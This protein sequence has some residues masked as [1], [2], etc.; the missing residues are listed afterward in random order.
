LAGQGTGR[1]DL[2]VSDL[3]ATQLKNIVEPIRVY[4][5]EVGVSADAA[6]ATAVKRPV[7]LL[8]IGVGLAALLFLVAASAAIWRLASGSRFAAPVAE[9]AATVQ[10]AKSVPDLS[11]VVL[12][13]ANLSNDP[14]QDYFA[15][16]ITQTLTNDLSHIDGLFIISRNTA[17]TYKGKAVDARQIGKELGVR[18]V[19]EGSVQRDQSRVRVTAQLTDAATGRQVWELLHDSSDLAKCRYTC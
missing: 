11:I 4:S 8:R 9:K 14:A 3:G 15:D 10:P 13:F 7:R 18:Y 19:L 1:L 5:L 17:F 12:P 16:G 2:K 6:K